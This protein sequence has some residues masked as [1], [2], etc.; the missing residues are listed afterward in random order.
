MTSD[1]ATHKLV[2]IMTIDLTGYLVVESN[3]NTNGINQTVVVHDRAGNIYS[4]TPYQNLHCTVSTRPDNTDPNNPGTIT[5]TNCTQGAHVTAVTDSNGN[6]ITFGG[7][8]TM[9]RVA[10]MQGFNGSTSTTDYSGCV[11]PPSLPITRPQS[12]LTR[13]SMA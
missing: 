7:Q 1:A 6:Q 11:S 12:L 5:T 8:D 3:P 13:D 4:M 9:G 2:G 10:T